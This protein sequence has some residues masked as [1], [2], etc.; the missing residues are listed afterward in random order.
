MILSACTST[1][2]LPAVRLTANC[3]KLTP[4]QLP[5]LQLQNNEDLSRA[6]LETENAW[7][8]CAAQVDMTISCQERIDA[9]SAAHP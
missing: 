5:A 2:P 8:Q 6:L 9:Q 1:P 7:H 4:C 3:P